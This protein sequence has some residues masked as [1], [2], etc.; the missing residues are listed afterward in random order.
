[1]AYSFSSVISTSKRSDCQNMSS[2][3]FSAALTSSAYFLSA[4]VFLSVA[5]FGGCSQRKNDILLKYIKNAKRKQAICI[6][7]TACLF[8]QAANK[9]TACYLL[10]NCGARRV[11]L[12]PY[13]SE[14]Y[15]RK[16]LRR[17]GT[18]KSLHANNGIQAFFSALLFQAFSGAYVPDK[19]FSFCIKDSV[20]IEPVYINS[21]LNTKLPI[22]LVKSAFGVYNNIRIKTIRFFK[23]R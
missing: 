18:E 22:S 19:A 4:R 5:L 20:F 10:E 21:S 23:S 14:R 7:K 2:R 8:G 12:R 13:C 1:M 17:K 3:T 15:G 16:P 11:P 6:E 9:Q